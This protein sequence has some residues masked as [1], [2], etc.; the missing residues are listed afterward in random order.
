VT[1]TDLVVPADLVAGLDM[2]ALALTTGEATVEWVALPI[3]RWRFARRPALRVPLDPRSARRARRYLRIGPWVLIVA[4][5]DVVAGAVVVFTD[6]R[7]PSATPFFFSSLF[8]LLSVP[9][10]G[11]AP[12][13]QGPVRTPAGDVRIPAVPV[14]VARQW[15][16]RNPGVIVTDEPSPRR[17]ARRYYATWALGLLAGGGALAVV[18]ANDGREESVLLWAVAAAALIAGVTMA[19]KT[20]PPGYIRLEDPE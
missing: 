2:P 7:L 9:W 16:A 18:F 11:G 13:R 8:V 17:H 3:S 14:E 20:L 5:L 6:A 15:A 10:I 1:R 4:A 12:P 19:L